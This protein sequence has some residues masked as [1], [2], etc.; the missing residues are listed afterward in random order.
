MPRKRKQIFLSSPNIATNNSLNNTWL[1]Y[2]YFFIFTRRC[3]KGMGFFNAFFTR[4]CS[5]WDEA[6]RGR[7]FECRRRRAPPRQRQKRPNMHN[8]LAVWLT[9]QIVKS[10]ECEEHRARFA[11]KIHNDS[12]CA[13]RFS[14]RF[15]NCRC[16]RHDARPFDSKQFTHVHTGAL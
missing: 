6:L 3:F 12:L 16:D 5:A 8:G 7:V 2:C 15:L 11:N 13:S 14:V 9:D 10:Q 1:S 4:T